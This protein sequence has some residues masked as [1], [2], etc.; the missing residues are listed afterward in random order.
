M[1]TEM[2]SLIIGLAAGAFGYLVTTFWMQPILLYRE[3]RER[4]HSNLI[5]YAD[6]V[7]AEG[8]NESMR[9]RMWERVDAN[10]RH[11][12][13]LQS[14]FLLLPIWY[15]KWISLRAHNPE[16][17]ANHLMGLSNTFKY[18]DTA[19]RVKVIRSGLGLPKE[20]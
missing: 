13:D 19:E 20:P 15:R 16:R 10:R 7:N 17:V 2:L 3:I 11:S 4:V 14:I 5:F 9:Q 12:A 8:L 18:D 1:D 6:V